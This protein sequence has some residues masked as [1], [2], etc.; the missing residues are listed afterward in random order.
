MATMKC[1]SC[2]SENIMT[3]LHVRVGVGEELEVEVR[4]DPNALVFKQTHREALKA[5]VCGECGN[6]ELSAENPAALW[7][8]YTQQKDS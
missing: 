6:V 5:T 4:G 3:N 1:S 7:K 2:G 8:V